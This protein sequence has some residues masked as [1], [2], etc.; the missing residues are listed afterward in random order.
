MPD[1]FGHIPIQSPESSPPVNKPAKK[2][3]RVPSAAAPTEKRGFPK[4]LWAV[5]A[6]LFILGASYTAVGFW[7]VPYY[8]T[9]V[10]SENFHTKTGM[11]LEPTTVTFNPFTFRFT[12]GELRILTKSGAIFMSLQSLL[13]D[14]APASLF[15]LSVL[16]NSVNIR[17]LDLNL[18]RERNGSYNF[19]QIFGTEENKNQLATVDFADLPFFFSLNNIRITDSRVTFNDAPTGKIHTVAKI[20]L[21]LPTFSNSPFQTEHYL[22]PHFSA[23]VNG[24]PVELTG[25]TRMGTADGQNQTTNLF[26]NLH[27]LDLT[28]YSGYLPFTLPLEFKKG[29]ADGKL[30]LIF[31]PQNEDGD[32]LTIGFQLRISEAELSKENRSAIVTIPTARPRAV[33]KRWQCHD[34]TTPRLSNPQA[35]RGH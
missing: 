35:N 22:R 33:I 18:V 28:L 10:L 13:A 2:P 15:R 29:T 12:T 24:S 1:H 17:G 8:V 34:C 5:I 27:D 31:N 3:P 26:L 6:A 23:I 14:V 16:C 4:I 19:Q 9:K 20:Q 25:Q 30:D 11:V 21:E 7:G 32:K